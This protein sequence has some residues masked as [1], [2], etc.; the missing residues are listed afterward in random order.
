MYFMC[1]ASSWLLPQHISN[2]PKS[3]EVARNCST[4]PERFWCVSLFG[5]PTNAVQLRNV[6][7]PNTRV[8]LSMNPSSCVF[9]MLALAEYPLSVV[10][11]SET[12]LQE[13]ALVFYTSVH[14]N[15]KFLHMFD[16]AKHHPT[17]FPNNP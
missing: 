1:L 15:E 13:S 14:F 12:F 8:L 7:Q 10:C 6:R 17:D 3:K 16:P 4:P 5:G 9:Y 2:Q 11:F